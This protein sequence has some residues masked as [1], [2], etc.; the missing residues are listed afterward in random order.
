MLERSRAKSQKHPSVINYKNIK[1][2]IL[3]LNEFPFEMVKTVPLEAY[4]SS[5]GEAV[6]PRL[7][8]RN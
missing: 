2:S 1:D 5:C 7:E 3:K 8:C 4:C 6:S